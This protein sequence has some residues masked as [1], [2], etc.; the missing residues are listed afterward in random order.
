MEE[1]KIAGDV[2]SE[3]NKP[4]AVQDTT[5]KQQEEENITSSE[6]ATPNIETVVSKENIE[7]DRQKVDQEETPIE[8]VSNIES[9]EPSTTSNLPEKSNIAAPTEDTVSSQNDSEKVQTEATHAANTES[10]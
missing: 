5:E 10:F 6:P 8:A 2:D 1:N 7:S 9:T 3:S 4:D